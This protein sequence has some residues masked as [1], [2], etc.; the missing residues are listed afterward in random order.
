MYDKIHYKLKKKREKKKNLYQFALVIAAW[1]PSNHC[2]FLKTL[3]ILTGGKQYL[4]D[5]LIFIAF[6]ANKMEIL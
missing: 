2:N 5:I 6:T 3:A 4:T 1:L